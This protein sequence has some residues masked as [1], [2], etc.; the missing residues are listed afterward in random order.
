MIPGEVL[1]MVQVRV[2]VIPGEVFVT[3]PVWV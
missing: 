2:I 3:V 1:V